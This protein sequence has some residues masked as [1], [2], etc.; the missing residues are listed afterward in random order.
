MS[1]LSTKRWRDIGRQ[2]WQFIAVLVTVVLGV[3]LFAASFNAYLNLGS[4]LE[5]TYER[6]AM[7]DM[8]VTGPDSGFVETAM[9]IPGVSTAIER[10][11]ADV[12]AE[13][14]DY[15]FVGRIIAMPPDE[16]PAINMV[17]IE[18]GSYL[19]PSDSLK[20]LVETHMASD[21]GVSVGDTIVIAGQ[22]VEIVGIAVSP[23]YLWPAKDA[24]N[25]FTAPKTFGVMFVDEAILESIDDPIIV[26]DVLVLYDS[27]ADVEATDAA[28]ESDS[29]A[30][31][32]ASIQ[33][34]ADQ[35]SNSSINLEISGL[36]TMAIAFPLLFLAA[37]GMAIYVVITRMV[38]SQRGV[39]G[40]L[41]ASGFSS[42][43]LSRHYL[44]YGLGLGVIGAAIGAI[45]GGIL[46]RGL[47]AVYTEIFD[48]P[49]LVAELHIPTVVLALA[50]G[51]IAGSLA[52]VPPARAVA[53]MAP[54][55]AMRGDAPPT[56]GKPSIFEKLIP[57]LKSAPVRWRLTLRGIGRSK[58][59]S[60]TLVLGVVLALTLIISTWGML[61]TMM[62]AFD[63]QFNEVAI[64]DASVVFNTQVGGEQLD[65]IESI[66]G[67]ETAEP[68]IGLS[69]TVHSSTASYATL[70][71]G[72]EPDTEVH[73]FP[74][75]LPPSG[76]V[77][78]QAIEGLLEISV[79]DPVNIEFPA[80]ETEIEVTVEGFVDEPL[81][82]FA[83]M[84]SDALQTA[85]EEADSTVTAD[86]L[87]QPSFTTSKVLFG[88]GADTPQVLDDIEALDDV[89]VVLD[90]GQIRD[91]L[92]EFQQ[93]FFVFVG[94]MLVFG[95][96]IAF[97]LIF[98]IVTVNVAERSSEYASMRANGLTH[99]KVASMIMGEV[100][101]LTAIG[102]VPGLIAGY[103]AAA[104]FMSTFE[105]EQF[106]ITVE[107][108]PQTYVISALAMFVVAFLSLIPAIRAVKRINVGE[109]VRERAI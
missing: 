56:S 90:E 11:Q 84:R 37:A 55:E 105:S 28:V 40:T 27:D 4:S 80:L 96:A 21:F 88:D 2:K 66:D 8:T 73:G 64:E 102:I 60:L 68:V 3:M 30:A 23:E 9:S 52:A 62:L 89:A 108:R 32:A 36:R 85:I 57:P 34:L 83:Y 46:G 44:S 78:G 95:G 16:Q 76:V 74:E 107:V 94:L 69:A 54:A 31:G 15:T 81:G 101:I 6:L 47:T 25:L 98:N 87:A 100:A 91:L 86:V 19:D 93:F 103:L 12:P 75:P 99:R 10:R 104:A 5:G 13:A 39:I 1:T 42:K 35:P 70:L 38:Y 71:E 79:G 45:I 41:R 67:V 26:D 97:A 17:D 61:D 20:V 51:A 109:I 24:Q 63:K 48:I 82:S 65:D 106:P 72:Y 43:T 92:E 53:R 33:P 22:E 29:E 18:E 49:D 77:L 58:R 59:R 14:G 7:A 50:F